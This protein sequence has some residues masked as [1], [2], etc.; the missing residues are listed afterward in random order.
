VTT[1]VNLE[2]GQIITGVLFNEAM[3]VE[4]VQ[5]NGGIAGRT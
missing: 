5:A 3:G 1:A 2:P 4:M